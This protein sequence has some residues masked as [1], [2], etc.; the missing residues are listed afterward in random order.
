MSCTSVRRDCFRLPDG[1]IYITTWSDAF[2]RK[3]ATHQQCRFLRWWMDV[4]E[5]QAAVSPPVSSLGSGA[6]DWWVTRQDLASMGR[7]LVTDP[8]GSVHKVDT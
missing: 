5:C 3:G 8:N 1:F 4:T 6:V 7:S 2:I